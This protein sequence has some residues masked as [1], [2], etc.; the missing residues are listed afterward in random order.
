MPVEGIN[1]I[2]N[3]ESAALHAPQV[4]VANTNPQHILSVGS[5]LYVS[6][7]SPD[8]LTVDGNVV[9]EGVKVGL[10]EIIP[11]YDLEA[12][13]NV[14]NTTSNTI[15]FTNPDTGIVTTGN[16]SVG[17]D[18]NV[19][20]N[21]NVLGT[22]T[23]IDT[24]NLRVKDP[25]I[26]L[27]KDNAGSLVDLGLVMTRPSG[28][29][30]VAVIFDEDTD[31]LE[32]GYTQ[33]NASD[34]DIA[35]RTAAIEPLSVN[36]NGNLSVTS[37][38]EVGTANLFVDTTTGRVGIG[39][40]DPGSALDVVGDVDIVGTVTTTNLIRG[41]VEEAVRWNSQNETVFPQ[42]ASTRYY[43]IA[44]LGTT[45]GGANGG[46]LRISG[47]IGG[48]GED[49]TTLIDGFVASRQSI[50][51]GGTL[52]GYGSDNPSDVDFVV[53][54]ES[55][56]TFAVWLKVIRYFVFDFTIMGAQVSNNTRT[57]AV[58][59][60]PTS[61]T[62]VTTPTGT[63]QGSVVDSCS[64]V[65]T[66]DG[67]VGIGTTNP[68]T[69]L[70]LS[71]KNSDPLATEG[72][73]VGTHTL[74]EYLRFT[75]TG[76]SGDV[77]SVSVGFKL[78]ADDNSDASPDGR[79]DIC[80]NDGSITDN[81]Y[82][83]IPDKTIATFLGGGRVGIGTSSPLNTLHLSSS[84]TSLDASGSATFDQYSLIIHN[85][86][87]S[88][89]NGSELGLCFNHYDSSYPSSTRTP[90]AAITHERTTSWSKGK[91]HFKTKSAN[92][93]SGSCDTRMTID[94]SGN[95][96]I[97][98]TNPGA[99]LSVSGSENTDS[100][101]AMSV[102][103]WK[104]KTWYGGAPDNSTL[105]III[106][107]RSGRGSGNGGEIAGEVTVIVHRDGLNQQRAY[108]K[109][110]VN[111]THWYGTTWYGTNNELHNYNLADVT[112]ISIQS[113]NSNGTIYV[114]IEAPNISSPGQYYIKF[115]GPIY[116]P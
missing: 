110:H 9:C 65:F 28:S 22:T 94:E 13:A 47:T 113:S 77:N 109:Y 83:T 60:C 85:T 88:G 59:P 91:L 27:G 62:S 10:I 18:L 81:A 64:V 84:N 19:T 20:G 101:I 102:D 42:S 31:T 32:I 78:G 55:D 37:N 40:T 90:G 24:E 35:M 70:H 45:G 26:E 57:L 23:T 75:S 48:F 4:G 68:R 104:T 38:V 73:L 29:S 12:V 103:K 96:G 87:G 33:S 80:A 6:G 16:V 44:T 97:G 93:E 21:L 52:T 36:V 43:K 116:K 79:L 106:F 108:A 8:V 66:D 76:D 46:K 105:N 11:S 67:N 61:D 25:I 2:L 49:E 1:G 89:S 15:Q 99:I 71:A 107:D 53:Y 56:G 100:T 41:V 115:E 54:E 50:R 82:G 34:T 30:N 114:S 72:D 58:L 5:N 111:Y 51:F 69:Y 95:V 39:K 3:V 7:D 86:R 14:G 98:V 74:T 63:L 17:K 112:N 92:T